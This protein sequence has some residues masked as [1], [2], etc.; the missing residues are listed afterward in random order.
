MTDLS[1]IF[2][3]VLRPYTGQDSLRMCCIY[4]NN[5]D[6]N[7]EENEQETAPYNTVTYLVL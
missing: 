4:Q 3:M 6:N 1:F 7:E 2:V 5:N